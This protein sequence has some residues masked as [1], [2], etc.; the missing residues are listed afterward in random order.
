MKGKVFGKEE[1]RKVLE[2]LNKLD[3]EVRNGW[4]MYK[5]IIYNETSILLNM[6]V[7]E[8][9]QERYDSIALDIVRVTNPKKGNKVFLT[10]EERD[11]NIEINF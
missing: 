5:G 3:S 8:K 2:K 4:K 1:L 10:V 7:L 6:R 11:I 9:L